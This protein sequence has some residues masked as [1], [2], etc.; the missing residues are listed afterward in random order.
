MTTF[1]TPVQVTPVDPTKHVNFT[2]GMVLGVDDMNQQF[3]YTSERQKWYARDLLGYGTVSGLQVTAPSDNSRARVLVAPGVAVVQSGE[4]VRVPTAQCAYLDDWLMANQEQLLTYIALS[5]PSGTV[6]LYVV[7]CYRECPTDPVPIAGEPCRS[8]DEATAPSRLTDDFELTLSFT[9]P[10]QPEEEGLRGLVGWLRSVTISPGASTPLVDFL[11]A[12]RAAMTPPPGSPPAS[13]PYFV[14]SPPTNMQ[15]NAD[16]IC[17]Y[18]HA[19][20]RVW[21]TELRPLWRPDWIGSLTQCTSA[22]GTNMAPIADADCVLLATLDVPLTL[23]ASTNSWQVA[24]PPAVIVREEQRPYVLHLRLLQE[25][26]SCGFW[27]ESSAEGIVLQGDVTG[28]VTDTTVVAI[29]HVP[30]AVAPPPGPTAGQVLTFNGTEWAPENLPTVAVPGPV[31]AATTFGLNP[32]DGGSPEYSHAD[33]SHG[34]PP[35]PSLG[36]DV[37]GQLG[38]AA[39]AAATKVVAIQ[40]MPVASVPAPGPATGQVLTYDGAAWAPANLPALSALSLGGDV[41]GTTEATALS[42]IQGKQVVA[43]NPAAGQVLTY[44]DGGQWMPAD[45]SAPP[46]PSLGGDVTGQLG[47]AAQAAATKVVAIQGMPVA[48]V[49]A[50]GPATGQVLTYDGAAWAPAN[51]VAVAAGPYVEHMPTAGPYFIIAA[52]LMK[53]G[54]RPGYNNLMVTG[55]AGD[56]SMTSLLFHFDG[57]AQ[58]I[59]YIVKALPVFN[60][61]FKQPLVVNFVAFDPNGFVLGVSTLQGQA[62]PL[63]TV[64]MMVEVS[65]FK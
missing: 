52:G 48:S 12:L 53:V 56:P 18:L 3:A 50:P 26:V 22:S 47:D 15:I 11:N 10:A 13:P 41:T 54:G 5:P 45:L 58:Q 49:P 34:T 16:D 28:Q 25:W 60:P 63:E 46:L 6:T 24:D 35:L 23:V 20:F 8:A 9:P 43:P 33:H 36:G 40:G 64:Q 4:L 14:G 2:L 42:A 19:A 39:Q 17:D 65:M 32:A 44:T 1:V 21:V 30:V 62:P 57:Y 7:L 37:T 27:G 38:D 59:A 31:A 61:E 55:T 51:P 29:Q